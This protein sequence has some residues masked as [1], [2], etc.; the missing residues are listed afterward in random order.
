M[1]PL[2]VTATTLPTEQMDT[3]LHSGIKVD[4]TQGIVFRATSGNIHTVKFD[5]CKL[6][7]TGYGG[8]YCMYNETSLAATWQLEHRPSASTPSFGDRHKSRHGHQLCRWR[9]DHHRFGSDG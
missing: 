4:G 1:V 5:S 3:M 8:D 6:H 7:V 2:E 9:S